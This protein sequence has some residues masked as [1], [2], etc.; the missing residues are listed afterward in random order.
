MINYFVSKKVNIFTLEYDGIKIYSNN[1]SKHF[2]I[3]DLER[4]ILE[5]TGVDIKLSFKNIE[6]FFP[7]FGIRV[8][9]N[10]IIN[11]NIIENKLKVVRHDH[12]FENN[13]ILDFIC[14][15]CNLQIKNNKTISLY[16]LMVVN[17]I[18]V[19]Y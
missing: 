3:N 2:S 8:S 7:D 5:K 9:T 4:I 16:F 15:E 13:N 12:A 18:I 14:R 17:M 1:K 6:D 19:L 10:N 11:E